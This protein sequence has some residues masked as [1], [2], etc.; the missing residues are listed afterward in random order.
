MASSADEG[1]EDGTEDAQ[2][3]GA[4]VVA[5]AVGSEGER[6]E[7][8]LGRVLGV[9]HEADDVARG[10]GDARDVVGAS[11]GLKST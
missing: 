5:G 3:V 9:G 2:A 6:A 1:C 8:G 11:I 7:A 10:V 4:A